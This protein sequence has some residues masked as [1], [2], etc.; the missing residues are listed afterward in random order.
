MTS[1]AVIL[2]LGTQYSGQNYVRY[3]PLRLRRVENLSSRSS[4]TPTPFSALFSKSRNRA[5]TLP[6]AEEAMLSLRQGAETS[7][8]VPAGPLLRQ[9]RVHVREHQRPQDALHATPAPASPTRGAAACREAEPYSVP[10]RRDVPP[11]DVLRARTV[12]SGCNGPL[13]HV[14]FF[15]SVAAQRPVLTRR[16]PPRRLYALAPRYVCGGFVCNL[17]PALPTSLLFSLRFYHPDADTGVCAVG[18]TGSTRAGHS[19]PGRFRRL[20]T[21][22]V[23]F[24]FGGI[25]R[26]GLFF[27]CG[28]ERVRMERAEG[29]F[30]RDGTT[31]SED[32]IRRC[33]MHGECTIFLKFLALSSGALINMG[34]SHV[35]GAAQWGEIIPK[36][37]PEPKPFDPARPQGF[38]ARLDPNDTA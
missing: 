22:F 20:G 25:W 21:P 8:S 14:L 30:I 23:Q 7:S 3:S 33:E 2:S 24:H 36:P 18:P 17:R 1:N 38:Q 34:K 9:R 27:V 29:Y 10:A 4:L 12:V 26:G 32:V 5:I 6:P 11:R 16:A 31:P 19:T 37:G 35:F 15:L 28:R 13:P